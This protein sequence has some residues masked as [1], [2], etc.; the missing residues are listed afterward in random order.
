MLNFSDL[1]HGRLSDLKNTLTVKCFLLTF[2]GKKI[3]F[4]LSCLLKL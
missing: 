1:F 3:Y 2:F 4:Y